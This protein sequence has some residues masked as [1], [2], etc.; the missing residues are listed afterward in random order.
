MKKKR[1]SIMVLGKG[2]VLFMTV[3]FALLCV[4]LFAAFILLRQRDS[5][6][7]FTALFFAV[8]AF[9]AAVFLLAAYF[10]HRKDDAEREAA[11]EELE[12]KR[13]KHS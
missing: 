12:K 7:A 11:W 9:L 5:G 10:S 2:P 13:Q 1:K 3:L 4:C 6:T 8:A